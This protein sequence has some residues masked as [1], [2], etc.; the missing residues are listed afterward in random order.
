MLHLEAEKDLGPNLADTQ[1]DQ[2]VD[3]KATDFVRMPETSV[4]DLVEKMEAACEISEGHGSVAAR[5]SDLL[6]RSF[7]KCVPVE[8]WLEYQ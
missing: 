8:W 1:V 2:E 7:Q 5:A 6:W 3:L 4:H